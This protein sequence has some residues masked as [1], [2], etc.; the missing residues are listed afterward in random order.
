MS[1]AKIAVSLE[2]V[3]LRKIDALVSKRFFPNRSK[4]IQI[5]LQEK[6]ARLDQV[7]LARECAKL[8]PK[9]EQAFADEGFGMSEDEWPE[10]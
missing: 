1:N 2:Q 4:A 6:L 9:L 5:A 7:D 3:L 10:Y 8:N